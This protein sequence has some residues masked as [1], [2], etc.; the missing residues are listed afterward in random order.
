MAT[1]RRATMM[2]T[3]RLVTTTTDDNDGD[4]D[5]DGAMGSGATG[6]D[7]DDDDDDD[8]GDGARRVTKSTM[9][10]TA[11]RAPT[12][13]MATM[14]TMTTM[15]TTTMMATARRKG[16]DPMEG[17]SLHKT[18]EVFTNKNCIYVR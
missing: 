10:A 4:G 6:Y 8:D 18:V 11:R 13:T 1:A 14:A 17:S 5:G 16:D 9:I 7:D 15:V 3:A 2:A 12:T